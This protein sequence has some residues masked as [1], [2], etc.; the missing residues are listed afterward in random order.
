MAETGYR[1]AFGAQ[2]DGQELGLGG[3]ALGCSTVLGGEVRYRVRLSRAQGT[4][5]DAHRLV[6]E[7]GTRLTL[8]RSAHEIG[9]NSIE[10]V[11][12]GESRLLLDIGRPLDG[13]GEAATL[14]PATLELGDLPAALLISH[15]NQDHYGLLHAAPASWSVHSGAATEKLIKLTAAI[16][17]GEPIAQVAE[18]VDRTVAEFGRLDAGFNNAGVMARIVPTA[19]STREDWDRVIGINLRGVWSCMKHELRQMAR[20]GGGAIVNNASVGALTGNPGTGSYIA[21]KHGVVGLTRTATLEYVR[22]SVRVNA[23]NPDL[24][25]TAVARDVV[26]GDEQAYAEIAK[27]VRIG[28]AGRPEEIASVVLWPCSPGSELRRRSCAHRGWRHD[29]A[30][31]APCAED[32]AASVLTWTSK[33][34]TYGDRLHHR[35]HGRARPRGGAVASWRRPSGGAARPI[36]GPGDSAG[37]AYV[38]FSRGCRR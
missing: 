27:N 8:H 31:I 34:A 24:I 20:Q 15:P 12:S 18:M 36:G 11:A 38:A 9:G 26:S 1:K 6:V 22:Q 3:A 10:V 37:R 2:G 21:S 16:I 28:R 14:L 19:E 33:G 32:H 7:A 5:F 25:D 23:V 35:Q 29:R 17:M 13:E 30:M 4:Q